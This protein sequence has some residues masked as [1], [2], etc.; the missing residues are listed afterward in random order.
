M[1]GRVGYALGYTGL[2]VAAARF[3]AATMLDLLYGRRSIASQT[4]LAKGKPWPFPPEPFRFMGIQ[5]TRWSLERE[6]KTGR[7]NLWLKALDKVGLG[8]DS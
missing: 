8:F 2:G 7:R 1:G 3:G 6:D 4:S 5:A